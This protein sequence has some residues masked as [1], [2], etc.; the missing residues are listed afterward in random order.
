MKSIKKGFQYLYTVYAFAIFIVLMLMVLLPIILVSATLKHPEK[1]VSNILHFWAASWF[2]LIGIKQKG[3]NN[4]YH[5]SNRPTIFIANHISYLDI[6]AI[7]L[8]IQHTPAKI[9]GKAELGKLP[10]FGWIYKIAVVSV[11]RLSAKSK[12]LSLQEL[13]DIL[14]RNVSVV[15]FPEGGFNESEEVLKDFYNGAFTLSKEL[16]IPIAP[17]LL[18]STYRRLNQQSLFSISAGES[19]VEYMPLVYPNSFNT[20]ADMK[21]YSFGVMKESLTKYRASNC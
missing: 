7:I 20:A 2:M 15:I 4:P 5:T 10:V 16:N 17:V 13:K 3:L 11:D 19:L 1:A 12:A 18:L 9:L 21:Q 8:A 6:P 14:S